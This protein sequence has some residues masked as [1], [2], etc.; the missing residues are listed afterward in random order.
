Q[1]PPL[2]EAAAGPKTLTIKVGAETAGATR[3]TTADGLDLKWQLN[4]EIAV[5]GYDD[6]GVVNGVSVLQTNDAD[7]TSSSATFTGTAIDGATKYKVYFP[8]EA[9]DHTTGAERYQACLNE[10]TASSAADVKVILSSGP[11]YVDNPENDKV[12]LKWESALLEITLSYLPAPEIDKVNFAYET[13]SGWSVD[14][15]LKFTTSQIVSATPKVY[16]PFIPTPSG[17]D[18]TIK[19]S[20]YDN[21]ACWDY[22]TASS[23]KIHQK[24]YR[25][26]LAANPLTPWTP[27]AGFVAGNTKWAETNVEGDGTDDDG[28]K[29]ATYIFDYGSFYQWNRN[30]AW[31]SS[32][33]VS[34]WVSST[35]T[36][37]NWNGGLGPCPN[38][39]RLPTKDEFD[40]LANLTTKEWKTDYIFP[41]INGYEFTYYTGTTLFLPAAGYRLES[42]GWVAFHGV[43]GGF[44]SAT[45]HGSDYAWILG[46]DSSFGYMAV[47]PGPRSRGQSV[48]CVQN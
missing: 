8:K 38:G 48:R 13:A 42:N 26:K 34:D 46:F 20:V 9:V 18:G 30:K 33:I 22:S 40:A 10:L 36:G 7:G 12:I 43:L 23:G 29:F 16:I 14:H 27:Y 28:G 37:D 6:G 35:P 47:E 2:D 44:W 41:G 21:D 11:D 39:W 17:V 15:P 24:G 25:Y 4:D 45:L 5:V 3:V 32:G 31:A 1:E 19:V